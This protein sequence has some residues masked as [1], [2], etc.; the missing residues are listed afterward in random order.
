[1]GAGDPGCEEGPDPQSTYS[2]FL[3][4]ASSHQIKSV[5]IQTGGQA[6][7]T[8]TSGHDYTT[9]IP[10]QLASSSLLDRLEKDKVSIVASTP[11]ASFGSELLSWLILLLP[12]VF[13]FWVFRRMSKGAMSQLQGAMGVGK[14]KAK[15]FDAE[16]PETTFADV[17]SYEG[18]KAE[19]GEVVDF[20]R[21]PERYRRAG[22]IAPRGVL[23]IGPPG[24][25][26][27]LLARAVAGEA[28]V[29]FFSVTDSAR[30]LMP[31]SIFWLM[32]KLTISVGSTSSRAQTRL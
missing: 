19:I 21:Q 17:A 30:S 20:L 13:I 23:M 32:T 29:P 12:F 18:A 24:T 27:T 1:V 3:H 9:V 15:V 28:E 2:Q 14:S 7:R 5:T 22:A 31:R 11:G 8:L 26:K 10:V 6:T 25:G 16:R 4:D